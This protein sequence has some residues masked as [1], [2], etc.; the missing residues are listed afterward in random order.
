MDES[1]SPNRALGCVEGDARPGIPAE[2]DWVGGREPIRS[3][4]T[5]MAGVFKGKKIRR[6]RGAGRRRL[7]GILCD[8]ALGQRVKLLAGMLGVNYSVTWEH[9]AELGLAHV[10]LRMGKGPEASSEA[11]AALRTHL[12]EGHLAVDGVGPD[13]YEQEFVAAGAE[14]VSQREEAAHA[15]GVLVRQL[16]EEGIPRLLLIEVARELVDERL[17]H[18]RRQELLRELQRGVDLQALAELDQRFPRVLPA[19]LHVVDK[20]GVKEVAQALARSRPRP[21][22]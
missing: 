14:A 4:R 21:A 22:S 10:A 12:M 19:I 3:R 2:R 5:D 7:V 17:A 1:E 13:R 18:R 6:A 8:E 11:L 9:L 20:Y 15:L 16:E